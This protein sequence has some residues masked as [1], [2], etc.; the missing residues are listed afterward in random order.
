MWCDS[1]DTRI[2]PSTKLYGLPSIYIRGKLRI[3]IP[4]L[5]ANLIVSTKEQSNLSLILISSWKKH[6]INTGGFY[7]KAAQSLI[8]LW[9][10]NG[11]T[12]SVLMALLPFGQVIAF[13]CILNFSLHPAQNWTSI[14]Y[15]NVTCLIQTFLRM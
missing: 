3:S 2:Y 15:N 11:P 4:N 13:D 5:L 10:P 8:V 6:L 14:K 1:L 7:F 12:F 9:H